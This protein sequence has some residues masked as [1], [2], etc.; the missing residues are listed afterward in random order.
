MSTGDEE[1]KKIRGKLVEAIQHSAG[2]TL[3]I[4][5]TVFSGKME[6]VFDESSTGNIPEAGA[7]VNVIHSISNPP[8]ITRIWSDNDESKSE[9]SVQDA[10][11]PLPTKQWKPQGP[12]R[13]MRGELI[14]ASVNETASGRLGSIT[15]KVHELE[16]NLIIGRESTGEIPSIGSFVF[17][18][19]EDSKVPRVIDLQKTDD[20]S[21]ITPVYIPIPKEPWFVRWPK[22]CMFCGATDFSKLKFNEDIWTTD[23]EKPKVVEGSGERV[24]KIINGIM[25]SILTPAPGVSAI[26]RK[27]LHL[28]LSLPIQMFICKDCNKIRLKYQDCMNISLAL[29]D[30]DKLR[31]HFE[32]ES[33][34]YEEYFRN[35]NPTDI[36][37]KIDAQEY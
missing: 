27:K 18:N 26:K 23:V 37:P 22:A 2:H 10:V 29:T 20:K 25:L 21:V 1:S 7:W 24:L 12:V 17:V 15:L 8:V 3:I 14:L 34:K 13:S 28:S 30:A 5:D 31:Y 11:I 9:S 4:V 19:F 35:H 32:F 36:E 16:V 6:L 33:P